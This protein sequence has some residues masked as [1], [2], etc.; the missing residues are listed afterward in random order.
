MTQPDTHRCPAGTCTAQVP[1]RL[2]A[3]PPHWGQLSRR[4]KQAI[5]ST[6]S[7]PLLHRDR[8]AALR[9]ARDE[10]TTR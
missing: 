9:A 4:A 6:A 10:W 7:L 2:L 1:N 8:R 5:R 3:C